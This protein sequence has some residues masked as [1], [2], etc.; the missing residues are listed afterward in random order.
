VLGVRVA[1]PDERWAGRL[2][3]V[4]FRGELRDP[5]LR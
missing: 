2:L 4:T 3:A 5:E 1:I